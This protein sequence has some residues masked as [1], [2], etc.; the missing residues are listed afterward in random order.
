MILSSLSLV[1]NKIGL[2][3]INLNSKIKKYFLEKIWL[4]VGKIKG[5]WLPWP[6]TYKSDHPKIRAARSNRLSL[7]QPDLATIKP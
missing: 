6:L 4:A 7:E 1:K 3:Q 2:T 5:R